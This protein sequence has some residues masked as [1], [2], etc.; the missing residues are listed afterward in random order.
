MVTVA[1]NDARK[2]EGIPVNHMDKN[3]SVAQK[4]IPMDYW[5]FANALL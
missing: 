4:S 3:E 5:P 2:I 1:G